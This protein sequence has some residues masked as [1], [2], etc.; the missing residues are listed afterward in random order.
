MPWLPR[1]LLLTLAVLLPVTAAGAI[2]ASVAVWT[3]ERGLRSV[4]QAALLRAEGVAGALRDDLD[5]FRAAVGRPC[6]GAM[7][8]HFRQGLSADPHLRHIGIFAADLTVRCSDG[9]PRSFPLIAGTLP[10]AEGASGLMLAVQQVRDEAEA[11]PVAMVVLALR[12]P[13]GDGAFA[14][15]EAR[16]LARGDPPFDPGGAGRVVWRLTNGVPLLERPPSGAADGRWWG[17]GPVRARADSAWMPLTVEASAARQQ[18]AEAVTASLALSV[19]AGLLAGGLAASAAR[20]LGL[21]RARLRG[22]LERAMR[23]GEIEVH[24]QPLVRLSDG[25]CIGAEALMRWRRAGHG[26]VDPDVFIPLAEDSGLI[27]D[28]TRHLMAQVAA[29]LPAMIRLQPEARVSINLTAIHLEAATLGADVLTAFG[30]GDITRRLIFETTERQLIIDE[31]AAEHCLRQLRE[32]GIRVYLDDFGTGHSGLAYLQRFPVDGIKIAHR[33]VSEIATEA[34]QRSVIDAII[35]LG[36]GLGLE[37][38]AEGVETEE[39]AVYLRDAAV[40]YGQGFHWAPPLPLYD[41]LAYLREDC[42][43]A[44]G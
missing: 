10:T 44:A 41:F 30:A 37:M 24:Y 15:L 12:G 9:G 14:I 27:I 22:R 3:V 2:G 5:A 25:R 26:L 17:L 13:L 39:Q 1:V 21:G 36:H 35:H 34:P 33:F 8:D 43:R 32:R 4:A 20:R 7:V 18:V 42:Q 23:R 28:L 11:A 6:N 31:V 29:D 38:I 40:G 16:G 19:P